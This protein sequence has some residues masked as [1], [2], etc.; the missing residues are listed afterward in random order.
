M[1]AKFL[2]STMQPRLA[3]LSAPTPVNGWDA[4][5][6]VGGAYRPHFVGAA[7]EL[8]AS[9]VK[10]DRSVSTYIAYFANEAPGRELIAH[11]NGLIDPADRTA[12]ILRN[13]VVPAGRALADATETELRVRS[14]E[15]M[16]RHWYWVG[17]TWVRRPEEVKLRQAIGRLLGRGD[18][19]AVVVIATSA[20]VRGGAARASLDSFMSDMAPSIEAALHLVRAS[21]FRVGE[22][23]IP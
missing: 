13:G 12:E 10:A 15:L 19:A 6:L 3:A 4:S 8:Q 14:A 7:S 2:D 11:G 23:S 17:G 9:Y 22:T 1:Y 21:R 16:V 20:G 5:D 18:D